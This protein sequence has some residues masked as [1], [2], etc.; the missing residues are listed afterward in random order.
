MLVN[1]HGVVV[2]AQVSPPCGLPR[3]LRL[4][5]WGGRSQICPVVAG[6]GA[7]CHQPKTGWV[8]GG[9]EQSGLSKS[10]RG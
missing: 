1:L 3:C 5:R 7:R 10:N 8:W 9:C 2:V 6:T 4:P